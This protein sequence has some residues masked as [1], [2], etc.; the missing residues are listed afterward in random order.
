MNP[1][2]MMGNMQNM[3]GN[4]YMGNM[5]GNMGFGGGFN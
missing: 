1:S 2:N 4:N 5:G 3:G